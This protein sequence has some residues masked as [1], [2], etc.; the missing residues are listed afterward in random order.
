MAYTNIHKGLNSTKLFTTFLFLEWMAFF[1]TLHICCQ[2]VALTCST[3]PLL[4]SKLCYLF[5]ASSE[6]IKKDKPFLHFHYTGNKKGTQE[7]GCLS[8]FLKFLLFSFSPSS[9]WYK[10]NVNDES[11]KTETGRKRK[12]E[13]VFGNWFD[14]SQARKCKC[15]TANIIF[16]WPNINRNERRGNV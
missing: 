4:F 16:S 12:W 5:F 15:I 6:E 10:R 1:N 13:K 11:K 2:M 3:F 14:I 9:F 7:C 8:A